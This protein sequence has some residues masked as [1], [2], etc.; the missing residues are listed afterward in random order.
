[1][2]AAQKVFSSGMELVSHLV[3]SEFD[4]DHGSVVR[5]IVPSRPQEWDVSKLAEAMLPEGGH[6]RDS[7][8]TIFYLNKATDSRFFR[9]VSVCKTK[10]NASNR[11]GADMKSLAFVC[12]HDF[13]DLLRP[14]IS[15]MLSV[16][17]DELNESVLTRLFEQLHAIPVSPP[18][19]HP[20][21]RRFLRGLTGQPGLDLGWTNRA[22]GEET[23]EVFKMKASVHLT[24]AK[25]LEFAIQLPAQ[26][27]VCA[28]N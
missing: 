6:N 18:A 21:E 13:P 9:C 3:L 16:C 4:I 14:L 15:R 23:D 28:N 8:F 2:L 20:Y 17:F 7:D 1:V 19:L 5:H 24:A 22:P 27:E 11:R 25:R 12:H 26:D 10:K